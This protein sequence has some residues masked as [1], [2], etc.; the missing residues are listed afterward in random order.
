MSNTIPTETAAAY[1]EFRKVSKVVEGATTKGGY[2]YGIGFLNGKGDH[3][4]A[5]PKAAEKCLEDI[6]YIK[7]AM[8]PIWI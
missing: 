5:F 2:I 3:M 7:G 6:M 1:K 4:K 8:Y